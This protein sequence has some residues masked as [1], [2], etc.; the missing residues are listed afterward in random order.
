MGPTNRFARPKV[1]LVTA[2]AFV[3]RS[4]SV[5]K[6]ASSRAN[7]RLGGRPRKIVAGSLGEVRADLIA[8]ATGPL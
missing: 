6:A 8:L 4:T 5:R 1:K 2:A 7:G 3:G